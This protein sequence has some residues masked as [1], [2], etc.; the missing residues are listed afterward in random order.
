[1]TCLTRQ[2]LVYAPRIQRG[3]V[4]ACSKAT[5]GLMALLARIRRRRVCRALADGVNG[6]AGDMTTHALLGF[7]RWVLV[8]D[9]VDF[10]E[11]AGRRMTSIAL[12]TVGIH[13][14]VRGIAGVALGEIDRIVV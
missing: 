9:R 2:P 6:I 13:R 14:G 8:V 1:M 4:E 11:I 5:A 10:L 3:V 12:P 7:N